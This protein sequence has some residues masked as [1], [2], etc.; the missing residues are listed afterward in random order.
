MEKSVQ[1]IIRKIRHIEIRTRRLVN[2]VFSGEYHSVFKG[3]GMEF[4][5]VR[6]YVPGDSVRSIDWNVTAR[7]GH[8]YVKRYVE[9]R[10]LTIVIVADISG[11]GQ[12]GTRARLK[13]ELAAELGAVLAF[14]AIQNQDNVGLLLFTDRVEKYVPPRKGNK[15][16]LR[17]I[18]EL[19]YFEPEGRG[20][21]ITEALRYLNSLLKRRSIVFV[22][23][24]FLTSGYKKALNVTA[25]RHDCIAVHI[26]DPREAELPNAGLLALEDAE[27][28]EIR[29]VD[30]SDGML[31]ARYAQDW[32][33]RQE[34]REQMFRSISVDYINVST[35]ESYVEPLIA[36]F[37]RRAQRFR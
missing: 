32:W 22:V 21:N 4:D 8:P 29:W 33:R 5:E 31:R 27:T 24:D 6:E 15:H 1:E 37:K 14:S 3:R 28:G 26:S 23:S 7:M 12:F 35:D 10:E 2:D 20:T 19:L 18:R 16:V 36:F 25:R 9:E 34:L 17:V 13:Q 30:T 11:S